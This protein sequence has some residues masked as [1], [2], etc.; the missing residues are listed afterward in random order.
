MEHAQQARAYAGIMAALTAGP[1][2]S[3]L[4]VVAL[5]TRRYEG[6]IVH[7]HL[8]VALQVSPLT[9]PQGPGPAVPTRVTTEGDRTMATMTDTQQ[10]SV[11]VQPED[12]KGNDTTDSNLTWSADDNGA[13]VSLQ[14]SADGTSC[15]FV[16][17]EPGTSNY[18]VT[19]GTITGGGT[20]TV[21]AGA[22]TQLVVT[23][24]QPAD[25]GA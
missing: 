1:G 24:G 13:V 6:W 20:I 2:A 3:P 15:L 8:R 17:N 12:S 14:P 11:S 21:T 5:A 16:A 18:S 19:D 10:V 4:E 25:Q 23:E 9:Y 22:A 7:G